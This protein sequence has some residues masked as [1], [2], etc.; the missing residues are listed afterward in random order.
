VRT[1]A[2]QPSDTSNFGITYGIQ[3]GQAFGFQF[4]YGILDNVC[5]ISFAIV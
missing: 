2:V 5:S 4:G 3:V 1:P